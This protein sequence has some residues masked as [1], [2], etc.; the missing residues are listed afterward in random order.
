MFRDGF[1][2][3]KFDSLNACN[4]SMAMTYRVT[5]MFQRLYYLELGNDRENLSPSAQIVN[6]GVVVL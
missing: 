1:G 4:Y 5:S 3:R 6:I 2:T